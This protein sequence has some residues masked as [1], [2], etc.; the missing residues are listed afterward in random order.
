MKII[1]AH[2]HIVQIIAGT[3]SNG[4]LRPIG[5]GQAIDQVG[6]IMQMIPEELGDTSFTY[7]TL[8]NLMDKNNI[9][10]AVLLQGNY[11]GFQNN[12]VLEAK[13]AYPDRFIV[14][15]TLDPHTRNLDK[16]IHYLFVENKFE[17]LK[18]E[19]SAGSGFL[20]N[21]LDQDLDQER[22][23]YIFKYCEE[24]KIR[25][26]LDLGSYHSASH[27]VNTILNL[28]KSYPNNLYCICH[29]TGP[30][31][32]QE[33]E[34]EEYLNLFNLPNVYF[35]LASLPS[36]V[37]PED[38]PYPRALAY[39][40]IAKKILGSKKLIWGSDIPS[41]L[42]RDQYSKYISYIT[43]SSLFTSDE[44]CDIFYNNACSFYL[45]EVKHG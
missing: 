5:K 11:F 38:Y 23:H 16:V 31:R 43:E 40:K 14:S 17:F 35:D 12:Y 6:N 4:E 32:D 21:H 45:K 39:L 3:T 29:L 24:H 42:T 30:R 26:V 7:H 1:D 18:L 20:C 34:L 36:N 19:L 44:L 28:I 15:A 9:E 37:R 2:A 41:T 33:K 8:I 22:F 10:K 25:L 13:K 27:Q